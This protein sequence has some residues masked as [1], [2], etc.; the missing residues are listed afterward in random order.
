[1]VV[2]ITESSFIGFL[3]EKKIANF[4]PL[5]EILLLLFLDLVFK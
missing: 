2:L 5:L 3:W 1:M 4:L